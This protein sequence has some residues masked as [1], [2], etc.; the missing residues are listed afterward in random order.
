MDPNPDLCLIGETVTFDGDQYIVVDGGSNSAC[1]AG[2][3]LTEQE[4][5]NLANTDAIYGTFAGSHQMNDR[6]AGCVINNGNGMAVYNTGSGDTSNN[7]ELVCKVPPPQ[8]QLSNRYSGV[9]CQPGAD[10]DLASIVGNNAL[11][12]ETGNCKIESV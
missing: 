5:E 3:E 6:P 1:A 9:V 10:V 8:Y 4:C 2:S 7:N 11:P 12:Y